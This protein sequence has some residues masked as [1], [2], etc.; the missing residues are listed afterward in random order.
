MGDTL[1]N[2]AIDSPASVP[3]QATRSGEVHNI[4]IADDHEV[5]RRGL[6]GL[7]EEEFDELV[8]GECADSD[9]VMNLLDERKWDLIL[10]DILMPR[11]SIIDMLKAI[12]ERDA[13]V[14]I[15]ILTALSE[16]EYAVSTLKAGANGYITKQYASDELKL[17]VRK[18]MAGESYLTSEAIA[19]LAQDLR[20]EVGTLPHE[21]LSKRELE[22]MC[23]IA[24]GK[25][26]KQIAFEL[27]VSAKTVG[28]YVARIREKT[29]LE[30]YVEIT[31]Y[32][33]Q[34]GLVD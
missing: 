5:V 25:A 28:T 17:A 6:K 29:G 31:R 4:L 30:N 32:A 11:M 3:G 21:A 9:G 33:L 1:Q 12:R 27:S 18:V 20:G 19:A 8:F 22:V 16:A 14:P 15:L 10:L 13:D 2:G 23:L 7:L 34:H 24:Q 26:V